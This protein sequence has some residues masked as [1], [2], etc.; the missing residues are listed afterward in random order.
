M[1]AQCDPALS[2]PELAK[3][4]LQLCVDFLGLLQVIC[5]LLTDRGPQTL[6]E[7][8]SAAG[9]QPVHSQRDQGELLFVCLSFHVSTYSHHDQS[10]NLAWLLGD[11]LL[12]E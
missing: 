2:T 10:I 9:Q 1:A 8:V 5:T 12:E 6:R 4:L 7:L 3:T 11:C